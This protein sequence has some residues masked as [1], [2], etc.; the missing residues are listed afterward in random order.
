MPWEEDEAKDD[1]E[2]KRERGRLA[3]NV[4]FFAFPSLKAQSDRFAIIF[5]RNHRH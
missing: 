5:H 1:E 4:G 2:R 3:H